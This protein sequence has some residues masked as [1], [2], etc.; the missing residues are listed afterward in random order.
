M[1]RAGLATCER[2]VRWRSEHGVAASTHRRGKFWPR[3]GEHQID[4]VNANLVVPIGGLLKVIWTLPP[5]LQNAAANQ[6]GGDDLPKFLLSRE[7]QDLNV[8]GLAS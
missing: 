3:R 4:K 8:T 5:D 1:T 2:R 7:W 6:T